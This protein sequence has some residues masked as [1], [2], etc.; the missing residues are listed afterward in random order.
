V[1]TPEDSV[2]RRRLLPGQHLRSDPSG[3]RASAVRVLLV[4]RWTCSIANER[5]RDRAEDQRP[6]SALRRISGFLLASL[7]LHGPQVGVEPL[8]RFADEDVSRNGVPGFEAI[9]AT[10]AYAPPTLKTLRRLSSP[11][12]DTCSPRASFRGFYSRRRCLRES[13]PGEGL[14]GRRQA[15]DGAGAVKRSRGAPF[16]CRRAACGKLLGL[17]SRTRMKHRKEIAVIKTLCLSCFAL[18]ALAPGAF[19]QGKYERHPQEIGF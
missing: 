18:A 10:S 1:A 9:H 15:V 7:L 16:Q 3:R 11:Q 4:V 14:T 19:G 8:Q 17:R 12:K 6:Q 2:A 13:S 5:R